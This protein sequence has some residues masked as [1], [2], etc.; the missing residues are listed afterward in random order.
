MQ[1]TAYN[2]DNFAN[3]PDGVQERIRVVRGGKKNIKAARFVSGLRLVLAGALLLGLTIS[4][5]WS[6]AS[7]NEITLDVQFTQNELAE[8]RSEYDY[9]SSEISSKS[10][11]KAVEEIAG[12][13]LGLMKID[14]SQITYITLEEENV[15][16]RPESGSTW[17]LNF[18]QC[19]GLNIAETLKP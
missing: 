11:L 9:L 1:Q 3:R 8:A 5:L 17:M 2:L 13:Q 12:S 15:V 7:L 4:L 6:Y 14:K 10:N 19:L 16:S 18:L